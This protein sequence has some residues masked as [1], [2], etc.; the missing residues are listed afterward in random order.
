MTW[1]HYRQNNSGGGYDIDADAGIAESVWIEARDAEEADYR[2]QRIGIYFNGCDKGLDCRRCGD[3][4]YEASSYD[5][6]DA[7]NMQCSGS[8]FGDRGRDDV[9]CHHADG[10][11]EGRRGGASER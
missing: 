4:W 5:S 7:P 1:F 6:G 10:R 3:R 8:Y 9:Y 11:I 2:A